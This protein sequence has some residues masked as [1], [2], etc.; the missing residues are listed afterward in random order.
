M[1]QDVT[2][3]SRA[4]TPLQL[5]KYSDILSTGSSAV[6]Y[7]AFMQRPAVSNTSEFHTSDPSHYKKRKCCSEYNI[8][9]FYGIHTLKYLF[10]PVCEAIDLPVR[11]TK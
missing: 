8:P 10:I 11:R 7:F 9:M 1:K 3:T 5:H 4:S 6:S 2:C